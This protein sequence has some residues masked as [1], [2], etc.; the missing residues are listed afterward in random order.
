M[1]LSLNKINNVFLFSETKQL[2]KYSWLG[3]KKIKIDTNQTKKLLRII[4]LT[5]NVFSIR[6]T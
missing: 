2:H 6:A 3:D 4:M 1:H 5:F